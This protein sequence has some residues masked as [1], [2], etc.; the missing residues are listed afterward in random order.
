MECAILVVSGRP[1]YDAKLASGNALV[2]SWLPGTEGAG[3]ADTLFGDKPYTGRLPVTWARS[4]DQLPINVGDATYDPQYPFGWGLRTDPARARLVRARDLGASGLE[5][6]LAADD[7]NADGS[8]KHGA[9]VLAGLRGVRHSS[10]EAD[11]LVVSVARDLAQ[12]AML[13]DGIAPASSALT[14][15][16]EHLL[17]TG[18]VEGA[19]AKL[20]QVALTSTSA[21]G[22]AGGTVPATLSLS[23]SGPATFGVFTPGVEHDYTAQ[24]NANVISTAGDAALSVSGPSRLTNGAFSL[25]S[26]LEVA[27][28]KS[29]WTAPVSNDAVGVSFKQHIDANEGLRT[30][31]YSSTLVF[32]L[33]TTSP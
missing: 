11:D 6:V 18:D 25:A 8:V 22:G 20:A 16:A 13:R 27:F 5:G 7:W 21:D 12:A 15:D 1:M 28:S 23:L 33:S 3:V 4:V 32:T 10:F 17:Y 29:A 2:A 19:I 24:T 31:T 30:G 9:D 14:A 26:P